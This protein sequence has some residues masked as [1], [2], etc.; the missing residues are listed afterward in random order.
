MMQSP[1]DEGAAKVE[2]KYPYEFDEELRQRARVYHRISMFFS[3]ANSELLVNLLL[4][5][6]LIA[7]WSSAIRSFSER[8]SSDWYVVAA[9]YMA[10]FVFII[11]FV[12]LAAQLWF[13]ST[14]ARL[15]RKPFFI[16]Q[17]VAS[18]LASLV[19][20]EILG[21]LVV[22]SFYYLVRVIAL[23]WLAASVIIAAY[24][25][26]LLL[27]F[28]P[29]V[30][31]KQDEHP[32][33]EAPQKIK[34]RYSHLL[35]VSGARGRNITLSLFDFA[36]G[37]SAFSMGVGER[38]C[39]AISEKM[40]SSLHE[41]EID[42]ILAHEIA[43]HINKDSLRKVALDIALITVIM[44]ALWFFLPFSVGHFGISSVQDPAD[45]PIVLLIINVMGIALSPVLTYYSRK[46]EFAADRYALSLVSD[47]AAYI[48][49]QKRLADLELAPYEISLFERLFFASHPPA[50]ERISLA[51][52]AEEK[53][54]GQ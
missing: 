10:I 52:I 41:N 18:R 47:R 37:A 30:L 16:G 44:F 23:W 40:L 53:R 42:V 51:G 28:S 31:A 1:Q 26:I 46:R 19:R 17:V 48:S 7:G 24:M 4:V 11:W 38:G 29:G 5:L 13:K 33:H 8:F 54:V 50:K 6:L 12:V 32:P 9:I 43:H 21:I 49:C 15:T 3:I 34:E 39:I 27:L 36:S 14:L 25:L 20:I 22:I 2:L 45:L 35:D